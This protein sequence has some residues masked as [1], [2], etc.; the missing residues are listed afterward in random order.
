M[1][2][3]MAKIEKFAQIGFVLSTKFREINKVE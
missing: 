1:D 2:G 3:K